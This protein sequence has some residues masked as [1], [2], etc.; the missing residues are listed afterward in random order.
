MHSHSPAG[1]AFKDQVQDQVQ[2]QDQVQE[3]KLVWTKRNRLCHIVGPFQ[4]GYIEM[5]IA[6]V[7]KPTAN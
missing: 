3:Q 5:D 4:K 6:K 7:Q 2:D 1:R